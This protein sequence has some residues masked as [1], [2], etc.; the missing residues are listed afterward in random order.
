MF[1]LHPKHCR[2]II[3]MMKSYG[4][5]FDGYYTTYQTQQTIKISSSNVNET[6]KHISKQWNLSQFV[7][8]DQIVEDFC[9]DN[10]QA[11]IISSYDSSIEDISEVAD[12]INLLFEGSSINT[13]GFPVTFLQNVPMTYSIPL[14]MK[15]H[16]GNYTGTS[17]IKI[18]QAIS[19]SF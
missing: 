6:Q 16:S 8:Y 1:D 5:E 3:E 12:P 13:V 19:H 18:L 11:F 2:S 15:S 14:Q 9:I 7:C 10:N 17:M 4:I